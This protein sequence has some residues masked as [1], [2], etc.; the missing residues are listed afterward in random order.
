MKNILKHLY[1][2]KILKL[3]KF[4]FLEKWGGRFPHADC[5]LTNS[6]FEFLASINCFLVSHHDKYMHNPLLFI[7]RA[8]DNSA[9]R[10]K[11]YRFLLEFNEFEFPSGHFSVRCLEKI[12]PYTLIPSCSHFNE[13]AHYRQDRSENNYS[14][15]IIE[16][17]CKIFLL[18][19]DDDRPYENSSYKNESYNNNFDEL[20][21]N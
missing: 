15:R 14:S 11:N 18:F 2:T 13:E 21:I 8:P 5:M 9:Y 12:G 10:N 17:I 7:M 20:I 16:I 1:E 6:D 3:T 4:N 19:H